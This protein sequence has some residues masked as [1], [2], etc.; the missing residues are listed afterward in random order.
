MQELPLRRE[1]P[2]CSAKAPEETKRRSGKARK[3]ELKTYEGRRLEQELDPYR[4][5]TT[6]S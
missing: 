6:T 4:L 3:V 2:S 1:V 5:A